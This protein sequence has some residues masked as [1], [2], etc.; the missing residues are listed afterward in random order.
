MLFSKSTHVLSQ[1][2]SRGAPREGGNDLNLHNEGVPQ[3]FFEKY[4]FDHQNVKICI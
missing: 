4:F 3:A 1:K 2:R